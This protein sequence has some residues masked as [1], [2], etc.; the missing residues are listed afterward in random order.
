M[1]KLRKPLLPDWRF[2]PAIPFAALLF[3]AGIASSLPPPP[4]AIAADTPKTDKPE[5]KP[6]KPD[7]RLADYTWWLTVLTAGIVTTG[8]LQ[9]L[10]LMKAD[11]AARLGA[12]AAM[13]QTVIA[14]RQMLISGQQTEILE[15]Q[16]AIQRQEFITAHR[17]LIRIRSVSGPIEVKGKLAFVVNYANVGDTEANV[18]QT[19]IEIQAFGAD[20]LIRPFIES[21]VTAVGRAFKSGE[22]DMIVCEIPDSLSPIHTATTIRRLLVAG[23]VIYRDGNGIIRATSFGRRNTPPSLR[24]TGVDD[25]EDMNW[26]D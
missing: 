4:Q 19:T 18:I 23:G 21:K 7:E 9:I 22:S 1:L 5:D 17:P 3:L 6:K 12:R 8:F 24:L 26:E 16:A 10:V 15:K 2:W 14:R 25:I 20:G 11:K 13:K